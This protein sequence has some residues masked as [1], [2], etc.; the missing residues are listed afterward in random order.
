MLQDGLT[1][2]ATYLLHITPGLTL[3]ALWFWLTPNSRTGLRILILLLAFIL[4]RD[5]MT[6]TGLWSLDGQVRIGFID[7]PLVLAALGLMSLAL[8]A[9]LRRMAPDL[10]SLII[11]RKGHLPTGLAFGLLAGCAIGI[12]LRLYQGSE[13]SSFN[14]WLA[15][16]LLL[17]YGGNALEE[18]LFRGLL[19]GYLEQHTTPLRAALNS[20]VAFAACH[21]FLAT[22]VTQAGWPVLAFTLIEG[23]ACALIRLRYGVIPA[24]ATHGTAI[25]LLAVPY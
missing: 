17:A 4:V 6:P 3:C 1:H 19:Q 25:V 5:A 16:M 11:W 12:P 8:I 10:R 9:L 2:L 13:F 24:I 22:T 7:N 14:L 21:V 18:V 20:A 23:L 15:G